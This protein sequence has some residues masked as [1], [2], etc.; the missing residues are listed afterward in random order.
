VEPGRQD[1]LAMTIE[2]GEEAIAHGR[3][4]EAKRLFSLATRFCRSDSKGAPVCHDP[5]LVQRLVLATYKAKEPDERKSLNE[6]LSL[7]SP[8]NPKES[9]DPEVV[10]L[11]GAIEKRLFD[12]SEG[13]DHLN[14]AI[15]F[16][17]RGF[18]LRS[19]RY[20]G[21]NLAYVLNMRA[22]S[23]LDATNEEKIADVVTAN[24]IRV[25]V[26]DLCAEEL[27]GIRDREQRPGTGPDPIREAE[28]GRDQE[29]KFWCL[30][31]QAEALLGLGRL[32]AFEAVRL[33]TR[34]MPSQTWMVE[35]FEQQI[36]RLRKLLEN[37]AHLLN[38]PWPGQSTLQ[39]GAR[40][41][42]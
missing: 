14:R 8:L 34:A 28:A 32:D 19:D 33:E 6:A 27:N 1:T 24:R 13:I 2:Q 12:Q 23:P 29:Q 15:R 9:N 21:I 22:G 40:Q 10:G 18:Y 25:E 7:L 42:L 41:T 11:A 39:T 30:A 16:Y 17:E 4:G 36:D 38:P 5:Y 37:Q 20:N 35:C 3:F 31:T 26:L